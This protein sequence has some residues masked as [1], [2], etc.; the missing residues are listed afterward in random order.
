MFV[1]CS[2]AMNNDLD[3]FHPC[4]ACGD[5]VVSMTRRLYHTLRNTTIWFRI[6]SISHRRY[7]HHNSSSS[8]SNNGALSSSPI[9][10]LSLRHRTS[11]SRSKSNEYGLFPISILLGLLVTL[12]PDLLTIETNLNA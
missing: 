7:L 3:S 6:E 12:L 9:L 10:I 5:L 8:A 2:H 1:L 11:S 4:S